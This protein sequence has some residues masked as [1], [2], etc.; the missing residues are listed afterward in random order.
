MTTKHALIVDDEPLQSMGARGVLEDLGYEVTECNNAEAALELLQK[1]GDFALVMVDKKIPERQGDKANEHIGAY[2]VLR[3][4][5][6]FRFIGYLALYTALSEPNV[7]DIRQVYQAGA[8]AL[9]APSGSD[10]ETF[11]KAVEMVAS[12]H[13][14]LSPRFRHF[15]IQALDPDNQCPLD[16]VE[17]YCVRLIAEHRRKEGAAEKWGPP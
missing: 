10:R 3:I 16:Q 5:R 7:G 15:G 8:S 14:V 17:Y 12:G 6:E 13:Q 9:A 2:L 1:G 4:A 11:A